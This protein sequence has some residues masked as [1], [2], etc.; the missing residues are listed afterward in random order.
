MHHDKRIDDQIGQYTSFFDSKWKLLAQALVELASDPD[1]ENLRA[2]VR[3]LV[4]VLQLTTVTIDHL[5]NQQQK[6]VL[7]LPLVSSERYGMY[8]SVEG[9][10][11]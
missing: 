4:T 3:S 1:N 9:R 11:Q 10:P 7:S 5:R 2:R 6:T 8:S